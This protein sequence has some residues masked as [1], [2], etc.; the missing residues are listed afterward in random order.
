MN[1]LT[2]LFTSV[3]NARLMKWSAEN[4]TITD[5][6]FG[7]RPGYGTSYAVFAL[8]SL[9][10]KYLNNKTKLYCCFVDYK[11]AFD[12]V[13][14]SKLWRQLIIYGVNGK[15]FQVI[16]SMY[17]QIKVCIKFNQEKSLFYNGFQGL[18]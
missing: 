6:Q 13:D 17:N 14:H 15:L 2:K 11:K 12:S 1:H 10:Q 9:I 7:F 4:D 8:H 18:V 5:S 16:K 3:L